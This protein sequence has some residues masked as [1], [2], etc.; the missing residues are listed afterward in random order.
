ML[1]G[2][3]PIKG[4]K[5]DLQFQFKHIWDDNDDD[6]DNDGD[7]DDDADDDDGDDNNDKDDP[8][9]T[10]MMVPMMISREISNLEKISQNCQ[11]DSPQQSKLLSKNA[12]IS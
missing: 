9:I 3:K 10:V 12:R 7:G 4:D 8:M 6:D 5:R 2:V 1:E 11:I